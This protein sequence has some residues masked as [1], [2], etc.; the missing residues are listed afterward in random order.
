V[1]PTKGQLPPLAP[2]GQDWRSRGA[3]RELCRARPLRLFG[4]KNLRSKPVKGFSQAAGPGRRV[5]GLAPHPHPEE[6][7]SRRPSGESRFSPDSTCCATEFRC[8][9]D[10]KPPCR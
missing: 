1:P 6:P 4:I 5:L 9:I 10:C 3:P 2:R 8:Q 7:S